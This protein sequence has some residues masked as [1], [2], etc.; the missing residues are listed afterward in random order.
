METCASCARLVAEGVAEP[1]PPELL[2]NPDYTDIAEL[3]RGGTGVLYTATSVMT[4][5]QEVLKVMNRDMMKTPGA[6]ER[7]LR[8]IQSAALLDHPNIVRVLTARRF[9]DLMVLAM[10]YVPGEDLGSLVRSAGPCRSSTP[11]ITSARPP[12]ASST[13]SRRAWYTGTSSPRT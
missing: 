10:E 11:A 1:I 3:S 7:F 8:E 5:R 12:T 6:A 4:R 2:N 13:P 9:G